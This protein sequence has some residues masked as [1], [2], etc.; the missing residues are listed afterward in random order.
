MHDI[1]IFSDLHLHMWKQ[2]GRD[3]ETGLPRRF[4]E[5]LHI[6]EQIIGICKER[7]IKHVLFGGDFYHKTGEV[8]TECLNWGMW[9]FRKLEDH[10]ITYQITRGNHDLVVRQQSDWYHSSV[11]MFD[12]GHATDLCKIK[13]LHYDEPNSEIKG[14]DIVVAHRT[15]AGCKVN[16]YTFSDGYDWKTLAANNK[17][18]L[19]GHIHQRQQLSDN[20]WIIGSPMHFN[21]GDE[22]DRGLWLVDSQNPTVPEF[23]KL[24]Y[25][26]FKTVTT[27][28]E[29]KNDYD[30]YRV[31]GEEADPAENVIQIVEPVYYEE[32]IKADSLEGMLAEW[33]AL[34]GKDASLLTRL[35]EI[36]INQITSKARN[37]IDGFL[38]SINIKNFLSISDMSYDY[39]TGVN[40]VI[41]VSDMFDSNGSGKTTAVGEA[42]YWCLFGKT[43]K[44]LTGNDVVQ[45]GAKDCSVEIV[46]TA[47]EDL[48]IV[49]RSRKFGLAIVDGSGKDLC[50]G[51]L[52][53]ERQ[54]VL[55][56]ILGFDEVL[57]TICAYF[58]QENLTLLSQFSDSD[59]T[60]FVTKLLDFDMFDVLYD[61]CHK[62]IHQLEADLQESIGT[63]EKENNNIRLIE[64]KLEIHNRVLSEIDAKQ[65]EL[66]KAIVCYSNQK[67]DLLS[68]EIP[69]IDI[70]TEGHRLQDTLRD[71]L[72]EEESITEHFKTLA[73]D[74]NGEV[75]VIESKIREVSS[76]INTWSSQKM[77]NEQIIARE[78]K[79]LGD[80]R[81]KAENVLCTSCGS[82][83]TESSKEVLCLEHT[84]ALSAAETTLSQVV[85]ALSEQTAKKKHLESA[86]QK[87]KEEAYEINEEYRNAV[88]DLGIAKSATSDQ[89][90]DLQKKKSDIENQKKMLDMQRRQIES[91]ISRCEKE[92]RES[93]D[94]S[95]SLLSTIEKLCEEKL[96]SE[97]LITRLTSRRFGIEASRS[98]MEFWKESFST[99]GIRSMLI[100]RFCNRFNKIVG[101]VLSSVSGGEMSLELTPSKE[102]KSGEMRNKMGM[103]ICLDGRQVQYQSLSGGEKRRLDFSI[104]LSLNKWVAE[105]YGVK[106]GILGIVIFDELFSFLD[107][108][109]E[110]TIAHE[111]MTMANE[112]CI[113]VIS[114]TPE[115][116]SYADR[117]MY[118]IKSK[119]VSSLS[120]TEASSNA[121]MILS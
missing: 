29:I 116:S 108:L 68:M 92:Y 79:Y 18:V 45:H 34:Q 8:A 36:G 64:S 88:K 51:R 100:D 75:T 106:Q 14:Y 43:S 35:N 73:A 113:Y 39:Q 77:F 21:F 114:H 49:T 15:P 10:G 2:F 61:S 12:R 82:I 53:S 58:S 93:C 11:H 96:Q 65:E 86:L 62:R 90:N 80:I 83:V 103:K 66:Q 31:I 97:A 17:L 63:E 117:V 24:R 69:S 91:D 32:K 72:N 57:F 120:I 99:K 115:L 48:F 119:G 107:K 41:G 105:R 121:S 98:D 46:I 37:I 74:L 70:D 30:Y 44:G 16:N 25:P 55:L 94:K 52:A 71:L 95:V 19:F 81:S 118:I 84:T 13:T 6:L 1:L 28:A 111:L 60:N 104:C 102:L 76:V 50:A 40:L 26:E 112:R 42:L 33:V 7:H 59:K 22:G 101:E 27:R 4:K 85:A 109:G 67:S 3:R 20:C 38:H 56:E 9:F 110:E 54:N 47:G 5:Q 87:K 78:K 23:V 89:I